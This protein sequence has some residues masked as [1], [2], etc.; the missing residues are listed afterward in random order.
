MSISGGAL[1]N[2]DQTSR[3]FDPSNERHWAKKKC[4]P[5]GTSVFSATILGGLVLREG[6]LRPLLNQV[7]FKPKYAVMDIKICQLCGN[8]CW[9]F[10]MQVTVKLA[11]G[12]ALSACL[13]TRDQFRPLVR[14]H[15]RLTLS[16]PL[17]T[18][19]ACALSEI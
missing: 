10:D 1:P 4:E 12:W 16:A 13:V 8:S 9:K 15:T 17:L 14:S 5:P 18:V 2:I 3:H 7:K 11:E 6:E 19:A